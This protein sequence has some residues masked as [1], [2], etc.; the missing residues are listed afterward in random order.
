MSTP[1]APHPAWSPPGERDTAEL[2]DILAYRAE[3]AIAH[4]TQQARAPAP[5]TCPVCGYQGPFSPVRHKPAIWCPQCDSRPRHR[6]LKLWMDREMRLAPGARVLHFAAEP[7][8]RAEM[9]RRGAVYE[10]AD[11]TDRFDLRLDIEAIALADASRDMVIANHVL[12]HVD[13]AAALAEIARILR[14]GGLAVLTVPLVEGWEETYEDPALDAETRR[15]RYGDPDHRRFY[16]RDFR[17]RIVA[18]GL[19]LA[20][21]AATEP[22][23]STH[24]LHRGE[25][26]FLGQ[27]AP[28]S[29]GETHG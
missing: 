3:R 6:L 15:L 8:V 24:A 7:W 20:D 26:L 5:A 19:G 17:D 23:V 12:E 13:D 2:S 27:K 14:P 22:D 4:F 9:A 28:S 16:G 29:Q 21:Y 10:T 18:A 1:A 25:R 11:I